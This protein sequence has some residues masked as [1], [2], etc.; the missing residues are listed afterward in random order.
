MDIPTDQQILEWLLPRVVLIGSLYHVVKGVLVA[1]T[2]RTKSTL[3]DEIVAAV[4][5]AVSKNIGRVKK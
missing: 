1:I 2:K 5:E 4:S 3:D